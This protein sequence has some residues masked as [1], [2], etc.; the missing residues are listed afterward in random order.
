M[1]DSDSSNLESE[2]DWKLATPKEFLN[3]VLHEL[4]TPMTIISGYVEILSNEKQKEHH[5]EAIK[6][7]SDSIQKMEKVCEDIA[8][9]TRELM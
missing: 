3:I 7:I 8:T 5:P 2:N 4:R 1:N 9:Y 6:V